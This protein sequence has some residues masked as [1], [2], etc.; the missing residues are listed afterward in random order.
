MPC[1]FR[2]TTT[3][4]DGNRVDLPLDDLLGESSLLGDN[5]YT[6]QSRVVEQVE[7]GT[8]PNTVTIDRMTQVVFVNTANQTLTL[9]FDNPP[10]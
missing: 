2:L 1:S 10:V 3:T 5:V 4:P 7:V 8:A 6:E 9:N